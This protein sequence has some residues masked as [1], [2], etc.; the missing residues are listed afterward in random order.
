MAREKTRVDISRFFRPSDQS[1]DIDFLMKVSDEETA[2]RAA[3]LNLPLMYVPLEAIAP[4]EHQLRRLP[5]PDELTR[6]AETGDQAAAALL[7]GLHAL[8]TSIQ[9]QGQLQPAIVYPDTDPSNPAITHRLLHGQR[10]WSAALLKGIPTLWVV[11]VQRPSRVQRVLRQ[12]DENE[13]REGLTDMERAWALNALKESLEEE[14]GADVPWREIEEHMQISEPR[15]KDLLR[16]LRFPEAAQ[17]IILRHGWSEWTLRP[18]HMAINAGQV[19][20]DAAMD[21]VQKLMQSDE[22]SA[23]VVANMVEQYQRTQVEQPTE[24]QA[25][26]TAIDTAAIITRK[27]KQTIR[28]F[29]RLRTTVE[30]FRA[31]L[32]PSVHDATMRNELREQAEELRSSLE[33][34]LQEL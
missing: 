17:Q 15:R 21:I 25:Q 11:E 33:L 22:V 18:L 6:M 13:R 30:T 28:H 10:R 27:S 31:D 12:F 4:D 32:L 26:P 16:L 23:L 34:L 19:N 3:E 24:E 5:H 29:S 14:A 9:E 8:G 1:N 20:D 7:D 2:E